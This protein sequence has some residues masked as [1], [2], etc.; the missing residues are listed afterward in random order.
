MSTTPSPEEPELV[1]PSKLIHSPRHGYDINNLPLPFDFENKTTRPIEFI[2]QIL[3]GDCEEILAKLPD[4]CID[5]IVTSPPYADQRKSTYG[6]ISPDKYVEWF[7]PKANQ[8]LRVLKPGG[9]FILNIK[10]RVVDGERHTYVMELVI[11]MRRHGWLWTEEYMWHKKNSHPGK[12]PNRFRDNWEHL[13]QFNKSK[14]FKMLQESVMV[15]VGDW[16]QER[17][18]K[19]SE[20]D[21]HRDNS[22]VG[23]GF[24]KNI[25]NWVG[26]D[27]V[28]PSNVLHMATECYNRQHSA[29]FPVALPEWFIKLFT[30]DGDTVLDPFNGSGTTSFAAKKLNR[31]F[32]GIDLSQDYCQ[33]AIDRINN[34]K[35]GNGKVKIQED[36]HE[37]IEH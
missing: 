18:K 7:M 37:S 11:E 15:P 2:D 1:D 22:H 24:G 6:G 4:N 32:I 19:L 30:E 29:S 33:L 8:F 34:D 23:S 26:R 14:K 16:A 3:C 27:L 5:L 9:T 35:N 17:L 28:Y 10:E 31:H 13:F 20:T 12:W 36:V 25:S 21:K